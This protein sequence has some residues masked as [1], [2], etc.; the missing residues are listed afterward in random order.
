ME[1]QNNYFWFTWISGVIIAMSLLRSTRHSLNLSYH[2]F[3]YR[4]ILKFSKARPDLISEI[5]TQ[6]YLTH[7]SQISPEIWGVTS[8]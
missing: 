5:S 3:P 1:H 4:E 6:K 2:M 8:T 7:L